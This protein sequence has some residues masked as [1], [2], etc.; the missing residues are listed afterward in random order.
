MIAMRIIAAM[1]AGAPTT[2]QPLKTCPDGSILNATDRCIEFPDHR[3]QFAIAPKATVHSVEWRCGNR[4]AVA[5]LRVSALPALI[6]GALIRNGESKVE[7][8]NVS[9]KG[10]PV[11]ARTMVALRT[12]VAELKSVSVLG[13]RCYSDDT[14]SLL[15]RGFDNQNSTEL[16]TVDVELK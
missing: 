14:P 13:G 10:S 3:K 4:V 7:L 11:S 16:R 12:G 8:L 5:R 15:I 2:G 6:D 9:V 1:L